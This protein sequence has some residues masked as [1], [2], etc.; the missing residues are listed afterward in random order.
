MNVGERRSTGI[1]WNR[2]QRRYWRLVRDF[3]VGVRS[4]KLACGPSNLEKSAVKFSNSKESKLFLFLRR[5]H[6]VESNFVV[7]CILE[8]IHSGTNKSDSI[9]ETYS[10][11]ICNWKK[12]CRSFYVCQIWIFRL[13]KIMKR[14]TSEKLRVKSIV[15]LGRGSVGPQNVP[16]QK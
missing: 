3:C 15:G 10:S 14:N 7:L 4:E 11:K 13:K 9:F 2:I 16:I 12:F 8:L 5:L 6:L 1:I